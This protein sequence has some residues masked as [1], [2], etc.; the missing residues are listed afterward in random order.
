M[1]I[2]N[3]RILP[4][5][6]SNHLR[7]LPLLVLYLT[8]GCNSKCAMC[9]IWKAPR[10]NMNMDLVERLVASA[11]K[12]G[13]Q[14]VLLSGGEAMQH[15]DWPTIARQFRTA[16][17]NVWL[18][19][20][21]LLLRKQAQAVIEHIDM[22]TVSLDA[23]TPELYQ[24]IRGVDALDI[25]LEGM[26]AVSTGGIPISTRTT[27]MRANFRQMPLLIDTALAAGAESVSFL[28]VDT[29]NPYA[30]GPRFEHNAA[31]PL[32][33][34]PQPDEFGALTAEDL[35]EFNAVLDSL[36]QTHTTQFTNGQIAESPTKLRRLYDYFAAPHKKATFQP[37]RCN[38]P[39]IS[40]VVN[41]DGKLQPCYFLPAGGD[42]KQHDLETVIN[43]PEMVVLRK[44]YRDGE[45]SECTRC[46]C[47]LYRG[48]RALLRGF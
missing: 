17:I 36:E 5:L 35:P 16:G 25:I 18:L 28:A 2:A 38:A 47:P 11:R 45:R 8:D 3:L 1:N 23:A 29:V 46:V 42:L 26:Q 22:L 27:L 12:L 37:P 6:L 20:N 19:T 34:S 32:H 9:D 10:R 44:A 31:I 7:A 21:G 33:N 41:V 4:N 48:P 24:K 14:M 30:F 39:H 15:P 43:A 13:T 40:A